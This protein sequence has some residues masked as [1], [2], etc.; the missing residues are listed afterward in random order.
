MRGLCKLLMGGVLVGKTGVLLWQAGLCSCYFNPVVCWW[1]GLHALLSS[2]LTWGDP[3]LGS[4]GSMLGLSWPPGAHVKEPPRTAKLAVPLSLQQTTLT[5]AP[6]RA[7]Q[8]TPQQTCL[9]SVYYEITL[10]TKSVW[11][12]QDFVYA[13]EEW[14]TLFSPSLVEVTAIESCWPSKNS[15]PGN[16]YSFCQISG[17]K[18]KYRAPESS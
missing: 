9:G 4:T 13:L 5:H 8:A 2:G 7:L 10:L 17:C 15:V 6:H 16:F 18:H 11:Y 12:T 14:D 1:V 3:V